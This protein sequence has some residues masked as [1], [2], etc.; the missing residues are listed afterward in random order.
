MQRLRTRK[1]YIIR[2]RPPYENV[3]DRILES[4]FF[5][6]TN[7]E[8]SKAKKTGLIYECDLLSPKT[9]NLEEAINLCEHFKNQLKKKQILALPTETQSI[10]RPLTLS[11]INF[12]DNSLN[13]S[14]EISDSEER[15]TQQSGNLISNISGSSTSSC[16]TAPNESNVRGHQLF[17]RSG[18]IRD[19]LSKQLTSSSVGESSFSQSMTSTP[20]RKSLSSN[21]NS[22][23]I[24][25]NSTTENLI[26]GYVKKYVSEFTGEMPEKAL[27]FPTARTLPYTKKIIEYSKSIVNSN[28]SLV[29][30]DDF[31]VK[32]NEVQRVLAKT[33]EW[34]HSIV[35][36]L[37]LFFT[38]LELK[39]CTL[40]GKINHET[41]PLPQ[42]RLDV[43]QSMPHK[44][45]TI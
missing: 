27:T 41:D 8:T 23:V 18:Y 15:N 22:G 30:I 17:Q 38:E 11:Y 25:I 34:R 32:A 16:V 2:W 40:T 39:T 33:K 21:T 31:F 20:L 36:L 24:S 45:Y 29:D 35:K 37:P 26:R 12:N 42:T 19:I 5:R 28:E 4:D 13:N 9:Y 1:Y 44:K 10:S 14:D 7:G 6:G 3:I 43:L